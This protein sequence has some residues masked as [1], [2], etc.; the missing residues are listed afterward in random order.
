MRYDVLLRGGE[1]VDPGGGNEGRLDVAVARGRIAA[2]APEIP[3]DSA[4]TIVDAAGQIVT[5][6]LVDLHT[7]VFHKV[8]YWGIDPDPVAARTGVT[9]W[10]DA[11]SAG[12]LTVPGFRDFAARPAEVEV[13]AFMNIS[14]IG[15]VCD[16]YELANDH[17]LDVDLF[18]RLAEQ[19]SDL[20]LGVKVRIATRTSRPTVSSLYAAPAG[21]PTTAGCR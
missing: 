16:D 4:V 8:T 10:N 7:H 12:A 19:H 3:P 18:R 20:V 13:T 11:G 14:C 2:V 6:G 15:L 17:Y 1:V 9:T 5:P 21:L